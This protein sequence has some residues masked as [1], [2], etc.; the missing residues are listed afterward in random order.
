MSTTPPR[1][2]DV[3]TTPADPVATPPVSGE[4]VG[5]EDRV[6]PA[7]MVGVFVILLL[8]VALALLAYQGA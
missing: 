8:C 5:V 1:E 6:S 7:L 3:D 2:T 4:P